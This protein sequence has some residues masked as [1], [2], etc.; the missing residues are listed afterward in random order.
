M[1]DV[2]GNAP[3]E[4]QQ[5]APQ[6]SDKL[7]ELIGE[8]KKYANEQEAL[9]ALVF[10][11]DHITHLEGENAGLRTDLDKRLGA[12]EILNKFNESNTNQGTTDNQG[13]GNTVSATNNSL[14]KEDVLD[15]VNKMN[16]DKTVD[17]NRREANDYITSTYGEKGV[18]TVTTRAN[19]LGMTVPQLQAIAEKSPAA[20]KALIT[21]V[22][23]APNNVA[24]TV[25]NQGLDSSNVGNVP[26]AGTNAHYENMRKTD[27]KTYWLPSTQN[28][29]HK[30]AQADPTKFFG[31]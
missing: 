29:L 21:G 30:A 17:A 19:E 27:A 1:T 14:T 6:A 11:Q 3:Q 18:E 2:F 9:S 22:Q 23:A 15:V 24:S 16:S 28:A 5:Q 12:E 31:N 26:T 8:G 13:D 7:A 25:T 20:F 4:G 10:A